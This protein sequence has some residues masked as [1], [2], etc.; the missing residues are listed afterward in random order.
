M[1]RVTLRLGGRP[2]RD[3][4][5]DARLRARADG[6]SDEWLMPVLFDFGRYLLLAC[7]RAGSQPAHLQG[8]W[9]DQVTP[10]WNCD[11]TL[12]I[13]TEMNYWPAETTGLPECHQPLLRLVGELAEAG[14]G[15]ARGLYG[16][17]GWACHHNTDLWRATWPVGEGRDDPMWSFWPMGGVWLCLH[18]AEH[19]EFGR[20]RD[21]LRRTAWPLAAGAAS[22]AL[23]L[24]HEDEDGWLVTGPATSPENRFVTAD[25]PAA[26]DMSSTMDGTLL[27]ELFGFLRRS[28]EDAGDAADPTLLVEIA[29]ALPRLRPIAAGPDG[30]LLEWHIAR[31]ETEPTHRH[32]SHLSGVFPGNTVLAT[33]SDAARRSMEQR[34]DASTGWSTAW[35]AALWARLGDGDGAYRLLDLLLRPVPADGSGGDEGASIRRC[36]AR[37][38][39]SR[40]T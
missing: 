31:E 14:R 38:R 30:R 26:V 3:R 28:A 12:N 32:V 35:K 24:L 5:L 8:L 37:I 7:S 9:N 4:P 34:G 2:P 17:R 36:S 21:F 10:P 13:N 15:V 18:L 1:G 19:W 6:E 29:A 11:Y 23:D 27:R 22:F 40:S 20:D 25:G 16:A 33:H 39:R